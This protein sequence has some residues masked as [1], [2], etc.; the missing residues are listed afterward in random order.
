MAGVEAPASVDGVAQLPMDGASLVP[1]FASAD[2]TEHHRVQY[3]EVNGHRSI[4]RDGW[5][6]SAHHGGVPWTVGM[7]GKSRAFEEDVWELY[8]L[9]TDFS[10]AH[11]V[12]AEHPALLEELKELFDVEATRAGILPL[13]DARV[14]R[15]PLPRLSEGR[16]SFT[17]HE[18]MV[19]VPEGQAPRLLGR[20]WHL[21]ARLHTESDVKG[22]IATMGGRAAGWS[23]WVDEEHR[24]VLSYRTFEVD[25][26]E[27]RGEPLPAG[28]HVVEIV[29]AYDGPGFARPADLSLVVDGQTVGSGRVRATPPAVFSIDETFDIG[30]TSGSPVGEHP[31][32]F[33]FRGSS[34]RRVD[35]ELDG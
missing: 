15:A 22:V 33:P 7:P 14:R 2:A 6:A 18:G 21:A 31:V 29:S 19:G 30:T 13:Q 3:F 11:D 25:S 20:S 8:D 5:M 9:S 27:L 32:N 12:A 1:S 24:P 23:L 17:F 28:E 10:Q 35:L 26:V 34:I 4:Y 16:T